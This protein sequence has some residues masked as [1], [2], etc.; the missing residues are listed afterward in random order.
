MIKKGVKVLETKEEIEKSLAN[1][2]LRWVSR[3]SIRTLGTPLYAMAKYQKAKRITVPL[4]RYGLVLC[5]LDKDSDVDAIAD[6]IIKIV[7]KYKD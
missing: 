2:S 3:R 5:T 7:R 4:G 1:A 6:K